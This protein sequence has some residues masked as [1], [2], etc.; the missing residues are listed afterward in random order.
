MRLVYKDPTKSPENIYKPLGLTRTT[1]Y[2]Y[3]KILNNNTD[4][5]M[6]KENS[7]NDTVEKVKD[8]LLVLNNAI[9]TIGLVQG[10]DKE[11]Y[12]KEVVLPGNRASQQ[13]IRIDADGGLFTSFFTDF[14]SQLKDPFDLSFFRVTEY[15][16]ILKVF[17]VVNFTFV[18][19]YFA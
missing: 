11:G 3:S 16:L 17:I 2:R 10:V 6:E 15:D 18:V 12:L 13:M 8:T 4:E 14:Y 1:F 9:N 7:V 5:D 19:F